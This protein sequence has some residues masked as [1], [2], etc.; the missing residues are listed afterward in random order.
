MKFYN[1]ITTI[2]SFAFLVTS[3]LLVFLLLFS[4]RKNDDER[5]NLIITKAASKTLLGIII[6]ILL[7]LIGISF[8]F[9]GTDDIMHL[10]SLLNTIAIIYFIFLAYYKRRYGGK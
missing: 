5:R 3:V 10:I 9:I 4:L 8:V 2:L 7:R 1:S 6:I